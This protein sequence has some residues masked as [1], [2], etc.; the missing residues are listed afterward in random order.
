MS[1]D[2]GIEP[3]TTGD[4]EKSRL[5][6]EEARA[7]LDIFFIKDFWNFDDVLRVMYYYWYE[8]A[9]IEVQKE[10]ILKQMESGR[11]ILSDSA[12]RQQFKISTYEQFR[13]L[14]YSDLYDTLSRL[15]N[16][17]PFM[18][19]PGA[20]DRFDD[21]SNEFF[22]RSFKEWGFGVITGR[23][24]AGKTNFAC[25]LMQMARE[26][27][28]FIASNIKIDN[29]P[30]HI[31]FTTSF[32][33]L[34]LHCVTNFLDGHRTLIFMD[35]VPQFFTK[36]R[37]TSNSY[38]TFEKILFL[39]RKMGG[40]L[41]SIVQRPADV[42]SVLQDFSQTR[43]QKLEKTLLMVEKEIRP[44]Y[45][46]TYILS[47]VPG[48]TLQYQTFHSAS[49]KIDLDLD[50]MQNYLSSIEDDEN[51]LVTI[52]EYLEFMLSNQDDNENFEAMELITIR[53]LKD[54]NRMPFAV[55]GDIIG[56]SETEVKKKYNK[57]KSGNL[58]LIAKKG[59]D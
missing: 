5:L 32:T 19:M 55:I 9:E 8:D 46:K 26:M 10:F 17:D 11:D 40:N 23:P 22:L 21:K 42:P 37:A 4:F 51:Q 39:L 31:F 52:K 50:M 35:E 6:I 13:M 16:L 27:N 29:P 57:G 20:T 54:Y 12:F 45:M 36:K 56:R 41:I 58:T 49:F 24:N 59:G 38:V 33:K 3:I 1:V 47:S 53:Y 43:Y 44:G 18:K 15:G 14:I 25:R 34:L 48:T 30:E 28:F 7:K 2:K